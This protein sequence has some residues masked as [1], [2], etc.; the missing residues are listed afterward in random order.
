MKKMAGILSYILFL[1]GIASYIVIFL[2]NDSF[3]LTGVII[4]AIGFILA[5]YAEKPFKKI[6]LFGNGLVLLIAFIIPFIVTTFFWNE[7]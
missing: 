4:S 7:P 5:L 3:L 6:G 2:G 1:F